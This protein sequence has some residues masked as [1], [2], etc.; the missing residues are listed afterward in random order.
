[1]TQDAALQSHGTESTD[2][3]VVP[4]IRVKH[5]DD[6]VEVINSSNLND[7]HISSC[8]TANFSW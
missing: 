4:D 6:I 8:N 7:T 2:P 1:M 3:G 5:I